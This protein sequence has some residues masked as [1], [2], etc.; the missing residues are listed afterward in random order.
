MICEAHVAQYNFHGFA[1]E[2]V[3]GM[4]LE[5]LFGCKRAEES[6][7]RIESEEIE[8]KMGKMEGRWCSS[9]P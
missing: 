9:A 5:E 1:S 3:P 7:C 2:L 4:G 6:T 8:T